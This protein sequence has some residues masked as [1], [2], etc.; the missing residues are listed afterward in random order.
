MGWFIEPVR[1]DDTS[2]HMSVP[3]CCSVAL[4]AAD[5]NL[6]LATLV[7]A[8]A[9]AKR[10]GG[11]PPVVCWWGPESSMATRLS[12]P[13][14]VHLSGDA[15]TARLRVEAACRGVEPGPLVVAVGS[16]RPPELDELLV[17]ADALLVAWSSDREREFAQLAFERACGRAQCGGLLQLPG[18]PHAQLAARGI[19]CGSLISRAADL[20]GSRP[21]PCE[22]P[23][24]REVRRAIA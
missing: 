12:G 24:S 1:A 23:V 16:A 17:G 13:R 21:E 4:I 11:L 6:G 19:L 22:R 10:S 18:G 7:A 14:V 15:S 5:H 20:I 2:G 8:R 3:K 9:A